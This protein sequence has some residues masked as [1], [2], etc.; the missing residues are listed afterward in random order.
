MKVT[1]KPQL[2][3]LVERLPLEKFIP[4]AILLFLLCFIV[5]SLIT[6]NNIELYKNSLSEIDDTNEILR[7]TDKISLQLSQMQLY[8]RAYIVKNDSKYLGDYEES[9]RNVKEDISR[10][11][12]LTGDNILQQEYLSKIDS[13]SMII[14][15]MLDTSLAMFSREEK[16]SETQTA[17]ALGSQEFLDIAHSLIQDVKEEELRVLDIRQADSKQNLENTQTFIIVT[18]LFSFFILG[19]SLFIARRLIRNK[20][21]TEKL[22]KE[23]YDKLE[24]RVEER[25][26][27][28]KVTNKNLVDEISNRVKI[29]HSLRESENRFR[30]M[31]DSAPAL[32]WMTGKDNKYTYLNKGW[33]NFTG[34][35]LDQELGYGW[36]EGVHPEDLERCV[37][38]YTAAFD[39]REEFEMEYRLRTSNGDYRWIFDTGIPRFS[40]S[41]FTGYIGVCV[42]IHQKKKNERY[43]KIQYAVSKTLAESTSTEDALK[44]A[45][46]NICTGVNWK[47][48]IAWVVSGNKLIQKAIWSERAE[49]EE[50]Y[51]QHFTADYTFEPG[52]GLPGHVW[53]TKKSKWI[54]DLSKDDNLP[55]K[56]GLLEMGWNSAF[57][58]PIMDAGSVISIIECFNAEKLAPKQDLLE[59]L[60]SVGGQIG[61]FLVRKSSEEKLKKSHEELEKRINERTAE[62]V[63]TLN[64]LLDEIAHKEKIQ[65][66][67]NLFAHAIKDIKECVYITDLENNTLFINAAFESVYGYLESELLNEK[68]PV[69]YG[70]GIPKEEIDEISNS[71]IRQGWKGE[72]VNRRKDGTEF[73]ANLSTSVIRNDDGKVEAI[74]GI[75]QDITELKESERLIEKQS[76]L[77]KLLNDVIAVANKSSNAS[78]SISYAINKMCEYTDWDAGHCYLV[79]DEILISSGIWNGNLSTKYLEF[80]TYSEACIFNSGEDMPGRCYEK[81]KA[82]WVDI[83]DLENLDDYKRANET[84]KAGLQTGIWVPVTNQNKVTAVLE[85]FHKDVK[86]LDNDI[87]DC[88]RNIGIELGSLIERNEYVELIKEREKHFKAVADTANEAI[89]TADHEG[90]I[91][92]ANKSVEDIFGYEIDELLDRNLT[93]L[94]P[95]GLKEKHLKAFSKTVETGK[96]TLSGKTIEF[97]GKTK[98]GK[99]FPIELSIAKWEMNEKVYFTGMIKDITLRKQIETELIEKQEMLEKSQ[100]LAKLGSWEWDV[101]NDFVSWSDEMFSIY[102]LPVQ[103]F[104]PTLKGFISRLHPEDVEEIRGHIERSMASK[105]PFNFYER[106]FTPEGK[107]K[108]LKS[109]GEVI[110]D[111]KGNVAKLLGTCLDVTETKLAED[112]LRSSEERF[113]LLVEN[114]KDYSIVFLDVQGN[115]I[116]WNKGAEQ[117][118]GYR[119]S[120][121]VGKHVSVFYPKEA[122]EANEVRENLDKTRMLGRFEKQ[123]WRI[124]NDGTMFWADILYT[125]LFD[126]N[127]KLKGFI[128][129]TRDITE[130]KQIEDSIKKS[131]KRLKD[132]QE[133]AKLGNWEVELATSEMSWSEEMF[134]IFNVDPFEGPKSYGYLRQFIYEEDRHR[135]DKLMRELEHNPKNKEVE[136]RVVTSEG[137]MKHISSDIRIELGE[138]NKVARLYGSVQDI[139]DIKL[140]EEELRKTNAKLIE[141]QK[142]LIH[143]EK[144]AALGR[145]SSGIAHEI[146]NPL[147]NISALAQLMSKSKIEDEKMKKHLKYI[148]VNS[149]IAN[150]IIKDLLH[151]ASPEDLVF[152]PENLHDILENALG[153]IEARCAENSVMLSKQVPDNLPE[154]MLDRVKLDNALMNFFSNAIDAMKGGGNLSV[155]AAEDKINN[156]VVIDIIDSGEGISP[157]NLDKIFEPFFTTKETGTGLGLGLA[158]QTIRAHNGILNIS[159]NPGQGTHVEIKLPLRKIES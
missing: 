152:K 132:A 131:E 18:S 4:S 130:R 64:R 135:V 81:N 134:R 140:V 57:A 33:L 126:E 156:E 105:Q 19:L 50:T 5:L 41:E 23:S 66:K 142:E 101:R 100:K 128:K 49:D 46:E 35:T 20:S 54:E 111:E 108:I 147:A 40:G 154:M 63:K 28:L 90:N 75:A 88:I 53:K 37:Q 119:E 44:K 79:K 95:D 129:I 115:I 80:R 32:I 116:S 3:H 103:D 59:V 11:K 137:R 91:I 12:S 60:E 2:K 151:F 15:S 39:A 76:G 14:V 25:T 86:P 7:N 42:D 24:D 157:E 17:L 72:L 69:I 123:G 159:S 77:V 34:R 55:R 31:A 133:I 65:V 139:T 150:K 112:K 124:K 22:L 127:K 125:A 62:L 68:I 141:A 73:I 114:V 120:E 148:L 92:Y 43:L 158:Y 82:F 149:D 113:R 70:S 56:K 99:V 1:S 9:K 21:R 138:N 8:R 78:S 144:L 51:S 118:M 74:V 110:S 122:L 48:G 13:L 97:T 136:Y 26:A 6:Y 121:I 89:I 38:V 71:T 10:M 146:R 96:T 16:V 143:S 47:F 87:L 107:I 109:Q 27:E 84:I 104:D 52:I 94:I 98:K 153:S 106:I 83:R 102:E 29:E 67:L 58:I 117:T 45:L 85:F 30:E 61:N 93:V 155:K 145:F 36:S